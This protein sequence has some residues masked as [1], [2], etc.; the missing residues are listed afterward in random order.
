MSIIEGF[1]RDEKNRPVVF[2]VVKILDEG[3]NEVITGNTD[4]EGEFHVEVPAGERYSILLLSERYEPIKTNVEDEEGE[5]TALPEEG[6][7]IRLDTRLMAL[8]AQIR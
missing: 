1:A 4:A 2:A 7:R 5:W 6:R 3:G 8:F